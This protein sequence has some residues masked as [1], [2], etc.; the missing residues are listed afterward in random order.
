MP[1]DSKWDVPAALVAENYA[2]YY[3]NPNLDP[4][5]AGSI[6]Y[7]HRRIMKDHDNLI[8]W[9]E[10]NMNWSEVSNAARKVGD[11]QSVDFEDGWTNG[12]KEIVED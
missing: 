5:E 11:A 12:E 9:A 8:D 1:D 6:E 3:G 7:E 10:N 4:D 2:S